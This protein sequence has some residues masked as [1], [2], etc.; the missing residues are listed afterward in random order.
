MWIGALS[1]GAAQKGS[2]RKYP[3]RSKPRG[4]GIPDGTDPEGRIRFQANAIVTPSRILR[5]DPRLP[6]D[7][8]DITEKLRLEKELRE[9]K[10]YLENIVQ[11]SVDAIVTTIPRGG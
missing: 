8:P 10:D 2:C 11:S 7:C 9:T 3:A 5:K 6:G 1:E 4:G